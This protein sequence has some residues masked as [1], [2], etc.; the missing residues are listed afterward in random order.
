M[1]A[2]P[3]RWPRAQ[4]RPRPDTAGQSM[5]PSP[6]WRQCPDC[7][8]TPPFMFLFFNFF[9]FLLGMAKRLKNSLEILHWNWKIFSLFF[10]KLKI[11][12]NT[13]KNWKTLKK[14]FL[15]GFYSW[16]KWKMSTK[17]WILT[18]KL[19]AL[20]HKKIF[21]RAFQKMLKIYKSLKI[22]VWERK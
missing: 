7:P 5:R 10:G 17:H 3:R 13:E 11:V 16:K 1:W 20:F 14:N 12:E 4:T 21:K 8:R 22:T 9:S 18:K 19:K 2:W 6:W 15:P